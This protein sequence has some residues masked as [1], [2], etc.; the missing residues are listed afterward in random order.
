MALQTSRIATS[1]FLKSSRVYLHSSWV[2]R[3]PAE[4]GTVYDDFRNILEDDSGRLSLENVTKPGFLLSSKMHLKGPIVML[5]GE[6]FMWDVPQGNETLRNP[7]K[8]HWGLFDGWTK[9]NFKI[10]EVV[11]P[12][13]GT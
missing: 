9:D 7:K 4:G 3:Q 12:R 1:T 8:D 13:P 11:T 6:V 10:F 2:L 5:N